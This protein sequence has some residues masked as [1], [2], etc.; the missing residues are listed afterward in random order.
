[1]LVVAPERESMVL[2]ALGRALP[3]ARALALHLPVAYVGSGARTSQGVEVEPLSVRVSQLPNR[4]AARR[5][6]A[7][8]LDHALDDLVHDI[9]AEREGIAAEP[10]EPVGEY[11]P[12]PRAVRAYWRSGDFER[13]VAPELLRF[14]EWIRSVLHP[15]SRMILSHYISGRELRAGQPLD[16]YSEYVP[17]VRRWVGVSDLGLREVSLDHLDAQ[18]WLC[19]ERVG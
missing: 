1:M 15:G 7:A 12:L 11:S 13:V 8:A 2:D 6:H 10:A 16:L 3:G 4:P 14:F 19:L 5:F 17:I 18:W 9:I